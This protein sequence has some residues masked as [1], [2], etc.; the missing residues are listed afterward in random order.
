MRCWVR[1][2]TYAGGSPNLG[3]L[4]AALEVNSDTGFPNSRCQVNSAALTAG[5][6]GDDIRPPRHVEEYRRASLRP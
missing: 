2:L 6:E 5:Y 3:Q 4:G 1:A